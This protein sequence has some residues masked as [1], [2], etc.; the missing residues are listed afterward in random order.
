VD[1]DAYVAAH[2]RDWDRLESLLR[3]RGRLDGAEADELVTL[4]QRVA[5]HLSVVR[6]SSPDPALLGR[7]SSLVARAR[8]AVTGSHSPAWKDAAR[9]FTVG[10]PAAVY[11]SMR[12]WVSVAVAFCAV[13]AAVGAWVAANPHVQASIA[14]PEEIRQLVEQDF[15]A[16][17][18]SNPAGSFAA[19]VWTNNAW[20]AAGCL[21]LGALVG[22]PVVYILW[23][24]ALNVGSPDGVTNASITPETS[25]TTTSP[26]AMP[27]TARPSSASAC[28][29]G[30]CP[31]STTVQPSRS[32]APAATKTAV[33]SSRPC[34][35]IRPKNRSSRSPAAISPPAMPTLSAFCHRM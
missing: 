33:S 6:S 24:N 12:W 7:L 15:A 13:A 26:S 10:F 29:R 9:F 5:T 2:R 28:A 31:G 1:V 30:R 14:A 18:S 19:Q 23:Q 3:R 4:Y 32:P 20:V 11:R 8:S 27:A 34:G 25:S 21:I 22:F 17:Y 16:Y 35:R